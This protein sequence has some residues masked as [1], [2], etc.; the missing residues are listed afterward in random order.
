MRAKLITEIGLFLLILGTP[1]AIGGVH[2]STILIACILSCATFLSAWWYRRRQHK[3]L[4]ITWFG[5]VLLV[6]AGYTV[7]QMIP[8]PLPFLKLVAPATVE[9]LE[10]SLTRVG[11][12][13]AY[14]PIS[15]DPGSTLW[16]TL[17]IGTC[18]LTFIVAHNYLCHT[19][20]ARR[21]LGGLV[22]A[23]VVVTFLGFVGALVEPNKPLMLYTPEMGWTGGLINTSFVNG[24]HGTAFLNICALLAVGLAGERVS[25]T[26]QRRALLWL[27]SVFLGVGSCLILS[28]GGITSLVV[29]LGT[30]LGLWLK[31]SRGSST[32]RS[33]LAVMVGVLALFLGIVSWLAHDAILA[34]FMQT[35]PASG[36]DLGKIEQWPSGLAMLESNLWTGVGRGAFISAFPRYIRGANLFGTYSHMENQFLHLPIEWGILVGGG[37][38]LASAV[39]LFLWIYRGG[40]SLQLAAA[41]ALIALALHNLLD[42]NLEMLGIA[43]PAAVMAG[44]L[45]AAHSS[46]FKHRKT[47]GNNAGQHGRSARF[48]VLIPPVILLALAVWAAAAWP[49]DPKEDADHLTALG[50]QQVAPIQI[51]SQAREVIQRHPAHYFP[52]LVAALQA[53]RLK[54]QDT[55]T[56]LNQAQLLYPCS[57]LVHTQTAETLIHLGKRKQAIIEY[58]LAIKNHAYPERILKKYL[59]YCFSPDDLETLLPEVP[60]LQAMAI[61]HYLQIKDGP[62]TI[63]VR[64]EAALALIQKSRRRWPENEDL[65]VTYLRILAILDPP[66]AQKLAE[67]QVRKSPSLKRYMVWNEVV[68]SPERRV[69]ILMAARELYSHNVPLEFQLASAHLEAGQLDNA[70]MVVEGIILRSTHTETL[71]K[72]HRLL[73]KIYG[74]DGRIHRARYEMQRAKDLQQR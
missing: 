66:R 1:I 36:L 32:Q 56:Y 67:E 21:L 17:K 69:L 23:A 13:P 53:L 45:S 16:E 73:A 12:M 61:M 74:A 51:L 24:N 18:A 63:K 20:R 62:L 65:L 44:Y 5:G 15:L 68:R 25:K 34:A 30:L 72:A 7:F 9:V 57:P 31:F 6:A 40:H 26:P 2:H 28:R 38:I 41:A 59:K 64:A 52:H 3:S 8:L 70:R 27:T 14:H 46:K 10:I 47:K 58:G 54:Q 42:F 50:R 4:K 48:L 19:S 43:L 60:E 49:P 22:G 39:A 29:G 33:T 55:L 11:G 35:F 71:V 37:L